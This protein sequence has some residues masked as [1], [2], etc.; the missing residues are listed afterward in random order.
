M[1][2]VFAISKRSIDT[3]FGRY[4]FE[5]G[6]TTFEALSNLDVTTLS[7]KVANIE[8]ELAQTRSELNDISVS[9]DTL[10]VR[11]NT[12]GFQ[13]ADNTA[14]IAVLQSAVVQVQ[15]ELALVSDKADSAFNAAT[16]AQSAAQAASQQASAA[17]STA[18]TALSNSNAALIEAAAARDQAITADTRAQ[19]A[20]TAATAAQS[21]A[22]NALSIATQAQTTA[23]TALRAGSYLNQW[24]SV[25]SR[26]GVVFAYAQNQNWYTV[27]IVTGS[28]GDP[29][30][31]ETQYPGSITIRS[32][33]GTSSTASW[34]FVAFRAPG[35]FN[36]TVPIRI[37]SGAW[38]LVYGNSSIGG[39]T[40]TLIVQDF[41]ET[42]V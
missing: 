24:P 42:R 32:T 1:T 34:Q 2:T 11:V 9:L 5:N 19:N 30:M 26:M 33:T 25:A 3:S 8:S 12:Q 41:F 4:V 20:Q 37:R 15:S 16:V 35:N 14:N 7:A 28:L 22:N 23:T 13:I 18:A 27:T 10:T 40:V 17:S 39:T 31:S 29:I 6:L 21:A 36:S 38:R